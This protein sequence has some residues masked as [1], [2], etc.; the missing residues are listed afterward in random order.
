M[1]AGT[2][3]SIAAVHRTGSS[4]GDGSPS[5]QAVSTRHEV[6]SRTY[7]YIYSMNA[8]MTYFEPSYYLSAMCTIIL[9]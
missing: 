1:V 4:G 8:S 5:G 6:V 3:P 9:N 7:I 2:A